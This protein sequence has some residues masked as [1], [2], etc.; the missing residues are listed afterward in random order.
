MLLLEFARGVSPDVTE[1]GERD[2]GVLCERA[3]RGPCIEYS[4]DGTVPI[5]DELAR[6]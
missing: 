2:I 1:I 4:D 3:Q 5:V 6:R